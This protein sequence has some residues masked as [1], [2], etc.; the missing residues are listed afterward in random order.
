[1]R[2]TCRPPILFA[3]AAACGWRPPTPEAPPAPTLRL[4]ELELAELALAQLAAADWEGWVDAPL[5]LSPDAVTGA[6]VADWRDLMARQE[7]DASIPPAQEPLYVGRAAAREVRDVLSA[8]RQS[9]V[10]YLQE[11]N[12]ATPYLAE[13]DRVL[14]DAADR[15]RYRADAGIEVVTQLAPMPD[16]GSR[17]WGRLVLQVSAVDVWSTAQLAARAEL[18]GPAPTDPAAR[19]AWDVGN[20]DLGAKFLVWHELTHALQRAYLHPHLPETE[21]K[22][23]VAWALAEHR[24]L[25]VDPSLGFTWGNATGAAT[26]LRRAIDERQADGIAFQVLVWNAHLDTD[27]AARAWDCWFGRL[28]AA[29]R[30]LDRVRDDL[31]G[32]APDLALEDLADP[33]ADA[34]AAHPTAA[35][36]EVLV[37]LARR[38][39]G[40]PELSGHLTPIQVGEAAA[41]WRV[42]AREPA[43]P[44]DLAGRRRDH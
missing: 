28:D 40:V 27:R 19:L 43:I 15:I 33:L 31:A 12:V 8:A 38:L 11:K 39:R 3:L 17:D 21:R 7:A 14:P 30:Q 34:F 41:L 18:L 23:Q 32:V 13:L 42:L 4:P 22:S 25:D 9:F 6:Q 10:A 37:T 16:A 36:R 35:D 1:M 44:A 20:R 2:A 24:L 5:P 29:R 26:R